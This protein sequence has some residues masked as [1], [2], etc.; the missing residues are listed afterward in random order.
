M[1]LKL[2]DYVLGVAPGRRRRHLQLAARH[3]LGAPPTGATG[4]T[5]STIPGSAASR[6]SAAPTRCASTGGAGLHPPG[7]RARRRGRAR[8]AAPPVAVR[9]SM[10]RRRRPQRPTRPPSEDPP[11]FRLDLDRR[12][13]A[14]RPPVP[15]PPAPRARAAV[16]RAVRRPAAGA[17]G[18]AACRCGAVFCPEQAKASARL[19]LEGA[20]LYGCADARRRRTAEALLRETGS[21][22]TGQMA[23]GLVELLLMRATSSARRVWSGP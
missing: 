13:K 2:G 9:R 14:L 20:G 11:A 15:P 1:R 4:A 17:P 7:P 22:A 5:C 23:G 6:W 3:R 16:R 21:A 8:P 19:S 18:P 12:G 10:P